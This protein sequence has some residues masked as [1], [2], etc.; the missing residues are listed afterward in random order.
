MQNQKINQKVAILG[1]SPAV[2]LE[3]AGANRWPL[4]D[5]RDEAALTEVL[6]DGNLS[7]HPVI[8]QL[9]ADYRTLTGR[10]HALAHNNGTAALLAA[11][12]AIGLQPGDQVIVPSA[13]FWASALPML[14]LGALPV[15]CE[16]EADRLGPDPADIE[17][18]ITDRTRALVIVHLWG[19]PARMSELLALAKRHRLQIIEDA[20]HAHGAVW[21]GRPCGS[22]GDISVFSLQGDKLAP[23]G[24]GGMLLTDNNDYFERAACLGDI[25]RIIELETP[26][27]RFAAT[28][29]GL[30]TRIAPLSAALGRS[31]LQKLSQHNATRGGNL[32]YLSGRLESLGFD[33]FAGPSHVERTF[34]E[35]IIR[36]RAESSPLTTGQ[37]VTALQAEGCQV[38]APR[39]PLLHQQPF[40]TEGHYL[41]VARLP[42]E[43]AIDYAGLHLPDTERVNKELLKL[44]SFPNADR[45]ILDQYVVA[46]EK[47]AGQAEQIARCLR[48]R[49][50]AEGVLP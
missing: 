14:W 9:E 42:P 22:L 19:L 25:T 1:G 50:Y 46:F 18:R 39:Y 33:V 24:E 2:T 48:R 15:F 41:T 31:Q 4:L 8:R 29:F 20:S 43:Q 38:S 12:F 10:G 5:R 6:R 17:R 49:E 16:S 23:A 35:F 7:T 21:R 36:H 27:R 32:R 47:V 28:G 30:K 3:Q 45:E 37:L 40:F 26:A 11:F 34:F 13:T 44:P